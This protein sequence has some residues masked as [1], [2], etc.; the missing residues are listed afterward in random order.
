MA[1]KVKFL[2][3]KLN[4]CN[5][6]APQDFYNELLAL[7][8]QQH[9]LKLYDYE[10]EA[11]VGTH[12]KY[13]VGVVTCY[14]G[15]K[16]LVVTPTS[17][18]QANKREVKK[19][20]LSNNAKST[21]ATIFCI[22]PNTLTGMY[23]SYSGGVSNSAF[24]KLLKAVHKNAQKKLEDNYVT[25]NTTSSSPT[26]KEVTRIRREAK[27]H[28]ANDFKLEMMIR[29]LDFN[30]ILNDFKEI[31]SFDL[32]ISAA[33]PSPNTSIFQ[34]ISEMSDRLRVHAVISKNGQAVTNKHNVKQKLDGM[35]KGAHSG[36][37]DAL[38]IFGKSLTNEDLQA[39]FGEN[40]KHFGVIYLDDFI[41]LL[42]D[43]YWE[44][45]TSSDAMKRLIETMDLSPTLFPKP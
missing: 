42:P 1:T 28:F 4:F 19:I 14:K 6:M 29:N 30:T 15:D 26:K 27:A 2:G 41:D 8:S 12:Q 3:F 40:L 9:P 39:R 5:N 23:Y 25:S 43:Q 16:K 32:T 31:N 45:Y 24:A 22:N 10:Y 20:D 18:N 44:D 37:I 7:N 33:A 21:Q 17:N 35:I 13:W 36:D 11:I 38:T 34:P